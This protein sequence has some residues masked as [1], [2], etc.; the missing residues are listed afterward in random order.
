MH[1]V[2]KKDHGIQHVHGNHGHVSVPVQP[3][4]I[5]TDIKVL[6]IFSNNR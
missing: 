2:T 1:A 5:R 6:L 4:S 3:I